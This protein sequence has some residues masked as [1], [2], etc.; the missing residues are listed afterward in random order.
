[1]HARNGRSPTGYGSGL[2]SSPSL[3]AAA[4][5][6]WALAL[7]EFSPRSASSS[8]LSF[9]APPPNMEKTAEEVTGA[10]VSPYNIK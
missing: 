10:E 6:R 2:T 9:F 8:F 1:M 7:P 4:A 5:S 3:A